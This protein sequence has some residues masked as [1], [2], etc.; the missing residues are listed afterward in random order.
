MLVFFL[1]TLELLGSFA[2]LVSSR[3]VG[4]MLLPCVLTAQVVMAEVVVHWGWR[5]RGVVVLVCSPV[6]RLCVCFV[7]VV[8]V[9][10]SY[11]SLSLALLFNF[12]VVELESGPSV[13]IVNPWWPRALHKENILGVYCSVSSL[14]VVRLA[15]L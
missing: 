7:I 2:M 15:D 6:K 8:I 3:F 14:L 10:N 4:S 12:C 11:P 5:F 1:L 13:A 9:G